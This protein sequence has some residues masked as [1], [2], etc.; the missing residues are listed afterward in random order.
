MGGLQTRDSP[1]F[2]ACISTE[3]AAHG[4]RFRALRNQA[5]QLGSELVQRTG[6]S[7]AGPGGV[8]PQ[9]RLHRPPCEWRPHKNSLRSPHALLPRKHRRPSI[10]G[11]LEIH[12][13]DAKYVGMR[14][15]G[16]PPGG[17]GHSPV[18]GELRNCFVSA[19]QLG[20]PVGAQM[21]ARRSG[22]YLRLV[23]SFRDRRRGVGSGKVVQATCRSSPGAWHRLQ[24]APAKCY[25]D[26]LI[27]Q[28]RL[29]A[30]LCSPGGFVSSFACR[31]QTGWSSP[32][33]RLARRQCGTEAQEPDCPES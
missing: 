14:V 2:K 19:S 12:G 20:A 5:P 30:P 11:D 18:V 9:Q 1:D 32:D 26:E 24:H 21:P 3:E 22:S 29:A 8:F 25:A 27:R 10:G 28:P 4:L 7:A 13:R 33:P 6:G 23:Y 31:W 15:I 17:G 16:S